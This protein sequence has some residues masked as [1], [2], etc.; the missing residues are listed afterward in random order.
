M[1]IAQEAV[2]QVRTEEAGGTSDQYPHGA[3]RPTE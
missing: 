3:R 2:G 1:P